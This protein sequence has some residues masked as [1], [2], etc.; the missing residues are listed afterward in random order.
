MQRKVLLLLICTFFLGCSSGLKSR[1]GNFTA[2]YNTYYNAKKSYNAG[3]QKVLDS[4]VTYNAQQP[5]RIHEVPIN[6]GV[7]DFDKAIE[8]GAEIL[9]K[10]EDSKWVDNS[11]NL[12]GKSYYFK[13][14]YF[15]ADQKFQEI[16][17]TAND[18]SLIQESILWRARVLLEMELY[19]QGIQYINEQLNLKDRSWNPKKK[20]ELKSILAQY[21]VEQENWTDAI[22]ELNESLQDLDNK[23]YKERGYF[24]V[25]QL[26]E[27]TGNY[28]EAYNA[29]KTVENFY[30]DYDLQ[31]LALRKRAETARILGDNESALNT[32]TRMVKDDKNTE[33]KT[34]IDYEI[35]KTYQEQGEFED[36]EFI[37]K[38]LLQNT[39]DRPSPETKAL[40]YYGLAEIYQYGYNDFEM[41]AA[42]YDTSSRQNASLQKLP[43]SYNAAELAD[44]FGEYA[45]IKNEL[46]HRDSLLWVSNLPQQELDSLIAE[47]KKRKLNELEQARKNQEKQQNTLVNVSNTQE[48]TTNTGGNGFL[49]VNSATLQANARTQF[50]AVWG[51]RPLVDNWRV[52]ELMTTTG[53]SQSNPDGTDQLA[54]RTRSLSTIQTTVD[55]SEVPFQPAEK[56][57]ARKEIARLKYQLGNLFFISL[58]MPDSAAIYFE[59]VIQNHPKTDEV[60]VSYYS[61]SEIQSITGLENKALENAKKLVQEYPGSRYAKRLAEKYDLETGKEVSDDNPGL[62]DQFLS[63]K[64]D[65]SL[66]KPQLADRSTKL[67]IENSKNIESAGILFEAIQMYVTLAKQQEVFVNNYES[68][69]L[70]NKEW[71]QNRKD[72]QKEQDSAKVA[73]RDTSLTDLEKLDL[74][75]IIDSTL[76]KPDFNDSFPYH[77]VYWDK[78]RINIDLF[79]TSFKNSKLLPSVR[80]LKKELEKPVIEKPKLSENPE[81]E[82]NQNGKSADLFCSELESP[83]QIRGGLDVFLENVGDYNSETNEIAYSLSINQRGIVEEFEMVSEVE[84]ERDIK[85]DYDNAI[86]NALTFDPVLIE[87]EA[88]K[89][90]CIFK[91]PV[92]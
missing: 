12:I 88:V 66:T 90:K 86:E 59:D 58:E 63:L 38:N 83:P 57:E 77:G 20:A 7:Q 45:R 81:I 85:E 56:I 91:F 14:E 87:G 64:A 54:Q 67:A 70:K 31:Y 69:I 78:A 36:A 44:S 39:L 8:K 71:N 72:F 17:L 26:N 9:R 62:K 76:A 3:L 60:P 68:W 13:K 50:I 1:W 22:S 40:T 18:E 15:S 37:Y 82:E 41:A 65:T 73:I 55:L 61:L 34:E 25:G 48:S 51:D 16:A 27:R 84:I 24:L 92:R 30:Y 75:Q 6:A 21:Y 33:F 74:Q 52:R 32:F 10:H 19:G 79:I 29:Y 53:S 42:Y 11:L 23:K 89:I 4:K 2:Y 35:A 43:E 47:I 80:V 28:R 49:N 46:S 5:I